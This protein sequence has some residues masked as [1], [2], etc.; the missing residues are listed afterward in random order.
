MHIYFRKKPEF[1][2]AVERLEKHEDCKSLSLNSFLILPVQ[3]IPRLLLL[4]AAICE[5]VDKIDDLNRRKSD[6]GVNNSLSTEESSIKKSAMYAMKALNKVSTS[7]VKV[8]DWVRSSL[9]LV[10]CAYC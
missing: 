1:S 10:T 4:V 9:Y 6:P 3:R 7:Q 5:R 8:R 2:L